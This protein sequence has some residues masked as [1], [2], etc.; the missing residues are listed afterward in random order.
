MIFVGRARLKSAIRRN[1]KTYCT[2]QTDD[3]VLMVRTENQELTQLL[4]SCKVGDTFYMV[5]RIKSSLGPDGKDKP[6][7]QPDVIEKYDNLGVA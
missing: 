3:A 1:G 2:I 4:Q 5:G 6:Y 7:L